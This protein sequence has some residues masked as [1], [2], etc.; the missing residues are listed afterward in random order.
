ATSSIR[1]L[2]RCGAATSPD[3]G[4][5]DRPFSRLSAP[6]PAATQPT[7][8][9]ILGPYVL[10][11]HLVDHLQRL[12]RIDG[13]REKIPLTEPAMQL[14]QVLGLLSG[15]D[16][17]GDDLDTQAAAQVDDRA[18]DLGALPLRTLNEGR[19]D[20]QLIDRE[21][22]QIAQRGGAGAEIGDGEAAADLANPLD[23][24]KS[25]LRILHDGAL[26]DL[27]VQRGWMQR[28]GL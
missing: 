1:A 7:C 22:M 8:F 21:A 14:A 10:C 16:A 23:D 12:L 27:E 25:D 6:R 2:S 5:A 28:S 18:D 26:G 17:L 11:L 24:G 4:V 13:A 20:L 19:I 15:L 9:P 3:R